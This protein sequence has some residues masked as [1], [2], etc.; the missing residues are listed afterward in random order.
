[1]SHRIL[2]V[3]LALIFVFGM[4]SAALASG[5]PHVKKPVKKNVV[6]KDKKNH[7]HHHHKPR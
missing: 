2:V 1:M 3:F 4:S 5:K 7:H 6:K